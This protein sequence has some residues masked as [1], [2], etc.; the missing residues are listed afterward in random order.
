M[1]N[2]NSI[3]KEDNLDLRKQSENVKIPLSTE[4]TN[5]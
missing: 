1:L 4:D 2:Y 5:S 3:I